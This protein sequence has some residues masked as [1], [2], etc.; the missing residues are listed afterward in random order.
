MQQGAQRGD[1]RFLAASM[2]A[3]KTFSDPKKYKVQ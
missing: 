1:G 3:I 2:M